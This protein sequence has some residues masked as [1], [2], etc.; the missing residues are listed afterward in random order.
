MSLTTH[1]SV[2]VE[3]ELAKQNPLSGVHSV[4]QQYV[5]WRL[6]AVK[7]A[8]LSVIQMQSYRAKQMEQRILQNLMQSLLTPAH[9]AMEPEQWREGR[10]EE[11]C[12]MSC[13]TQRLSRGK[14]I[15]SKDAP[16]L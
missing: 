14:K 15:W 8:V 9:D 3:L 16:L 5:L 13:K 12:Q 10:R 6:S 4:L 2:A 1:H 11:T 7:E